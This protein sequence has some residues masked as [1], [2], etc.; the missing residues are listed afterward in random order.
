MFVG[1]LC[2]DIVPLAINRVRLIRRFCACFDGGVVA[3]CTPLLDHSWLNI[4]VVCR[5]MKVA[6]KRKVSLKTYA[7]AYVF[8]DKQFCKRTRWPAKLWGF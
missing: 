4:V 2:E 8:W 5:I 3:D 1:G 7:R 6:E